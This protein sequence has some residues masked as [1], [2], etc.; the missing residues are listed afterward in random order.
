MTI[1]MGSEKK[2]G[3]KLIQLLAYRYLYILI[4]TGGHASGVTI[5]RLLRQCCFIWSEII[6]GPHSSGNCIPGSPGIEC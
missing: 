1:N 3:S 6:V 5:D 4:I 2:G